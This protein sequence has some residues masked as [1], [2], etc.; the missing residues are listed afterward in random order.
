MAGSIHG[1]GAET[2]TEAAVHAS[3]VIGQ[4]VS[5]VSGNGW[6]GEDGGEYNTFD[7]TL[8]GYIKAPSGIETA[9]ELDVVTAERAALGLGWTNRMA[10]GY[11]I[12]AG[13]C[14]NYGT[15]LAG[16]FRS[17]GIPGRCHHGIGSDGWT[18]SFHVWAEAFLDSP[19]IHP[20]DSNWWDS[21]WYEFDANNYYLSH[22][23]SHSE[24][25]IS[26]IVI[27]GFGDYLIN[28]YIQCEG[29]G[30]DGSFFDNS[31]CLHTLLP[32]NSDKVLL[33][34]FKNI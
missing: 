15:C 16:M 21:Y 33:R 18:S 11:V 23:T 22:S 10:S 27:D 31:V 24:G 7:D 28:E 9:T 26:P 30:Y 3:Q 12:D 34:K 2:T 13:A 14:F 19:E 29:I 32:F 17:L 20:L 6:Y 1:T 4:R 8:I 5:W 25:S